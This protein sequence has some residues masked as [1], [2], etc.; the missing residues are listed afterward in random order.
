MAFTQPTPPFLEVQH[1]YSLSSGD[2]L[3]RFIF[4]CVDGGSATNLNDFA[5]AY[6]AAIC[7][8]WLDL[9]SSD[10][11]MLGFFFSYRSTTDLFETVRGTGDFGQI[12]IDALPA[13]DVVLLDWYFSAATGGTR[14]ARGRSGFSGIPES[15]QANGRLDAG[16][17]SDWSA[18]GAL[19]GTPPAFNGSVPTFCIWRPTYATKATV[20]AGRCN[21][22]PRTNRHRRLG[23]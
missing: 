2:A 21:P 13:Q 19:L 10:V 5:D 20:T 11:F 1:V 8:P 23:S 4:D 16:Y 12:N 3:N 18:W 17:I 6:Y 22:A 14:L 7:G 15:K 9:L